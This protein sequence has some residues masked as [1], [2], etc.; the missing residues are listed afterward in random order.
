MVKQIKEIDK[1]SWSQRS[2]NLCLQKDLMNFIETFGKNVTDVMLRK[3][4]N[5]DIKSASETK[6][7]TL[8]S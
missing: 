3:K 4:C 8:F 2:K 5:D 1:N 6:P 7:C